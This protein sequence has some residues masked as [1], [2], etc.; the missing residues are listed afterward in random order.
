MT[1]IASLLAIF[2]MRGP[3]A[4][5]QQSLSSEPAFAAVPGER[6]RSGSLRRVRGGCGL[7]E[8]TLDALPGHEGWTYGAGQ[9]IFAESPDRIFVLQRGELPLVQR[10]D[11]RRMGPSI[12]FPIGRLPVRDTTVASI[13][14]NGATGVVV[15]DA[16]K[17]WQA[18][19]YQLGVDA[20][21]E[22]CVLVLNGKGEVIDTWA[23]WD[24]LL[25]LPHFVAIDPYDPEKHVWIVDDHKHVIHKFTNDGKTK[26][27]T[28]GTYGE[29]GTNE[30]HFNRPTFLDWFA[31]GSFVVADGYYG[32]RVVKFDKHGKFL[33]AWGRE[34]HVAR[35]PRSWS[36][37]Q[38][39]RHRDRSR[40][41]PRVCE[42]PR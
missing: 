6:G 41:T 33:M 23:Q 4:S 24:S 20:R 17:T 18:R 3:K 34:E 13:P 7:A 16:L 2:V 1:V 8:G 14:T 40:H 29:A 5:G 38:R 21:W 25:Q 19:G 32:T 9:S 39:P 15:A 22:H 27:F 31:D 42:R 26:V 36:L 28:L 12:T 35:G 37:Q 11:I 10:P 30:R